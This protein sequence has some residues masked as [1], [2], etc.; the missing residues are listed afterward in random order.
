[1][2]P[3]GR[4]LKGMASSWLCASV[5]AGCLALGP[6]GS[7]AAPPPD[8]P[9]SVPLFDNLGTWHHPISTT[10]ELAQRYFD[11]GLRL[12]YA[13]NHEEAI[14]AF[15][16]AARLDPDAAMAYWGLALAL[17]P[18]INV[19]MNKQAERRAW[20]ALQKA[21]ARSTHVTAAERSYIDALSQRYSAKGG[22]RAAL[23]KAYANAMR[24][25]W[26]QYPDDADAGTLFADAVMNL[27]PWDLWT[28]EGAPKPGTEELI[29][30]LETVLTRTPEHP[31]AC[32]F[33]IHAVEASNAPERALPCAE[34]LPGLMPGAGHLV[35]MPAHI[36]MRLGHYHESAERNAHAARVDQEYLAVRTPSGIYPDGYYGHNLQFWWASLLM[37]GRH[38][39]ALRV[40]RELT[41]RISEED[42][43]KEKWKELFLPAPL[44][45]LIRFGQWEAILQEPVPP[46]GLP[47][48]MGMWRLGRGL[49]LA[50]TGRLP[51]AEGEHA[52]LAA[53][54]KRLGR[55]RTTEQKT[56]RT[57]LKL[58]ERLLA[59]DLA[60]R[61][62][63]YEAAVTILEE[64]VKLEDSLPYTE[65]PYWPL[66]LRHYLGAC[67]LM[68]GHPAQAE[69]VYQAD[70]RKNP[71]NG[72]ALFGLRQSLRAQDKA[73]DA[74]RTEQ[75]FKAAWAYADITLT[76]SRF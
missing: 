52:A 13:F 72:W 39:E 68:A 29:A 62:Q 7:G 38:A 53:L 11:Q 58:A 21:R 24:T 59:G 54:V 49:A 73:M 74:E 23:D 26:R 33:Y 32:H 42:A 44:Y 30:T 55:D 69:A 4:R 9:L 47:L 76:A 2:W 8:A 63:Q 65:P 70:L 28:A 35:H 37:E 50:A 56:E 17:G 71:H 43:R 27:R 67:L 6:P 25:H 3:R 75:Q 61:R 14:H 64:G 15:E 46:K 48:V 10:S 18:N 12:T 22:A 40:A 1:V 57:L 66:P 34:R 20:E 19:P 5:A 60:A 51:G 16:E 45:T 36:Y 31:G 41:G